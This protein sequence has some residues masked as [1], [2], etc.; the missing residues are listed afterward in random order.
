MKSQF[1]K[2][3]NVSTGERRVTNN[4]SKRL[5]TRIFASHRLLETRLLLQEEIVFMFL[6]G[7]SIPPKVKHDLVKVTRKG[8]D[9]ADEE[10]NQL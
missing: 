4:L 5:M 8:E 7:T 1:A 3:L 10:T 9:L 6:V 2:R